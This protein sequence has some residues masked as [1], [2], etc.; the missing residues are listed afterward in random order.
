MWFSFLLTFPTLFYYIIKFIIV[1]I[2]FVI[3]FSLDDKGQKKK[4]EISCKK[5][6]FY[7]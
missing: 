5:F 7:M 6:W 2:Q 4:N 3:R 1:L